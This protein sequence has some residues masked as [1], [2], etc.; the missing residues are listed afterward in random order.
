MKKKNKLKDF[1]INS[2]E[3]VVQSQLVW[4]SLCNMTLFVQ[5]V[6]QGLF[7]LGFKVNKNS[8]DQLFTKLMVSSK[9]DILSK[10]CLVL[11]K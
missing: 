5:C 7:S 8:F 10:K 3:N 4:N 11:E 2:S 6:F 9:I 1:E